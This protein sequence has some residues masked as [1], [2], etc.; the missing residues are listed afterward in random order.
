MAGS[1]ILLSMFCSLPGHKRYIINPFKR[2]F[3]YIG[4]IEIGVLGFFT[5]ISNIGD[6]KHRWI[7]VIHEENE[8]GSKFFVSS[9]S[10]RDCREID[11]DGFIPTPP[12]NVVFLMENYIGCI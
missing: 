3:L 2:W 6:H 9:N 11:V 10:N 7:V 1:N 4:V 5:L 12:K 8:H